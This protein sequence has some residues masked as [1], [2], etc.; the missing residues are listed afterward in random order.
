MAQAVRQA[1]LIIILGTDHRGSIPGSLT[2]TC[3]NYASPLGIMPTDR[4]LVEQLAQAL[5][6]QTVFAGEL[7]HRDEWSIELALIWL[8]FMR[9][10]NPCPVLPVLT[11]SFQHFMTERAR[12]EEE[13]Q[14]QVFVELLQAE[15]AR[16]R[17]VIV[18]SGDL[19]HLGPEFDTPPLDQAAQA[20]MEQDDQ[21][22]LKTLSQGQA[23]A[24]FEFMKAGQ[25]ERNVCGFPPFYFTLSLLGPTRGQAIG[26]ARCPAERN[27]REFKPNGSSFVSVGGMVWE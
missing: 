19:A 12:I 17:T 20:R 22:L 18:A 8:Q 23:K 10:G 2:L 26:Y 6:P 1:E 7:L 27:G 9:N 16:R 14:Y 25:Y 4:A 24:F 21:V 11:G 13:T 15:M 3:Q 5:G